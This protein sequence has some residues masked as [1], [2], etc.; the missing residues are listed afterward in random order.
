MRFVRVAMYD[1]GTHGDSIAGDANFT[2]TV[3]VSAGNLEYYVYAENGEAGVFH[4]ARAEREFLTLPVAGSVVINELMA[5]NVST[6]RDPGGDYDDWIELYN[7]TPVRVSLDGYLLTDDSSDL[8]KW[9]FPDVTIPSHRY[10]IVWAD[11]DTGQ[12]GL[13]ANFKLNESGEHLVLSDPDGY[14]VDQVVFGPQTADISF[15]RYPNGTGTFLLMNPTFAAANDSVVSLAE[16]PPIAHRPSPVI[17]F[18]NPFRQRTTIGY[19]LPSAARVSLRVY[20]AAGRLVA[21]LVD[22]WQERGRHEVRF[23]GA[24]QRA[25]GGVFFA[26]LVAESGRR[27]NETVKLVVTR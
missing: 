18:P 13:H 27:L 23:T 21:T 22:G 9:Q 5:D 6:A 2:T 12:A 17:V 25:S 15:G 10:L 1:D 20:D 4:P 16:R 3:Q 14:P 19:S 24:A 7:N 11:E 26:H 8:V